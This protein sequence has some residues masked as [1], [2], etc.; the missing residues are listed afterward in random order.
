MKIK[1]GSYIKT[2]LLLNIIGSFSISSLAIAGTEEINQEI[3]NINPTTYLSSGNKLEGYILDSG[4]VLDIQFIGAPLLSG[5]FVINQLGEIYLERIKNAYVRGLT[6]QELK[7]LLEKRYEEFIISP[8]V[9]IRI[10]RFKPVRIGISGEVRKA[11]LYK[12]DPFT[13]ASETISNSLQ[14]GIN[15]NNSNQSSNPEIGLNSA[16][17]NSNNINVK[18]ASD[19]ISTIS[20]AINQAGGLTSYSD[21]SKIELTR[22]IPFGSGGGKKR[23]I[24]NFKDYLEKS[25]TSLDIRL[26]DGDKIF[27]PKLKDAD[28]NILKYSILAGLTPRFINVSVSGKIENPGNVKIPLEGS[29]SDAMNLSGPRKPLSGQIYLIRYNKDGSLIR[30]NIKYLAK[31]K[32]GSKN[33]PYLQADDLITVKNS[34]LG[35]SSGLIKTITEPFI[36]LYT[37]KELIDNFRN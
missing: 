13:T 18:R 23:A 25:D 31:A 6:I 4:D 22:D 15:S 20:N 17:S 19:Y 5:D 3:P 24:I 12:L 21:I 2:I 11:G 30:R 10:I 26:Y 29:L 9:Y 34:F 32:A 16:I 14:S 37:T 36:G 8:E 7:T 1:K 28:P 27:I 33:N 35:R